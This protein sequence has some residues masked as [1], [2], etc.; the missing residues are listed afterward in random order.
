[1]SYFD[2]NT[3][4]T[5]KLI[6][7]SSNVEVNKVLTCSSTRGSAQWKTAAV[8]P[9]TP[10]VITTRSG[11]EA[12]IYNGVWQ[13]AGDN[14]R[15]VVYNY[16]DAYVVVYG[17]I[18]IDV[19]SAFSNENDFVMTVPIPPTNSFKANS[20][21]GTGTV[22]GAPGYSVTIIPEVGFERVILKGGAIPGTAAQTAT[23]TYS[24]SYNL[25]PAIEGFSFSI[26]SGSTFRFG[27][28]KFE[29]YDIVVDWGD[30]SPAENF[31]QQV[32]PP[33][34]TVY[35]EH[36]YPAGPPATFTTKMTGLGYFNQHAAQN[37]QITELLSWGDNIPGVN[38]FFFNLNMFQNC[39]LL[40]AENVK[41]VPLF[42]G[43]PPSLKT[44]FFK[45][46]SALTAINNIENWD[47]TNVSGM[48]NFF[49]DCSNFD[50]NCNWGSTTQNVTTFF[51]TFRDCSQFNNGGSDSIRNWNVGASTLF[52]GMFFGCTNFNQPLDWGLNLSNAIALNSMFHEC[53]NFNN[54]GSDSIN[55]WDVSS[56]SSFDVMFF[57]CP[58][59]NQPIG[60]WILST[61]PGVN[62]SMRNMLTGCTNFDQSLAGWT[63]GRVTD[64]FSFMGSFAGSTPA[65]S[66]QNYRDTLVSW[67]AQI[68]TPLGVQPN[69]TIRFGNSQVTGD[70]TIE[71]EIIA[72]RNE[73][74]AIGWT[75][76]DSQGQ[77]P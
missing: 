53:T 49:E 35:I 29:P 27:V 14:Q 11:E 19:D 5:K 34:G 8:P 71:A 76:F 68:G 20:L 17:S 60:N 4:R 30:G 72:A 66:Q 69:L 13:S 38:Q 73:L 32:P 2:T 44:N 12:I 36:T 26:N 47:M 25:S 7:D 57:N 52:S 16:D 33:E 37:N 42:Y 63:I 3:L 77:H 40:N 6:V 22:S 46:C 67:A 1:M 21:T 43:P 62:I 50:G 41:G 28:L 23:V 31:V 56:C 24:Y 9:S 70:P 15:E 65:L 74:V 59:F 58:N 45:G 75:I 39:N 48:E 51:Q 10:I 64:F 18:E 54:G 55:N 61:D